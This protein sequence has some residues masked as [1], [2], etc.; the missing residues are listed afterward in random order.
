MV[1]NWLLY[2]KK[3]EVLELQKIHAIEQHNMF[4]EWHAIRMLREKEC[5]KQDQ[6]KTEML[7]KEC[8]DKEN[9]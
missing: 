1:V 3:I 4:K 7:M 5:L 9:M 2:I 6:L 8:L